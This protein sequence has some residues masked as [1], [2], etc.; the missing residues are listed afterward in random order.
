MHRC[1]RLSSL[2]VCAGGLLLW[3]SCLRSPLEADAPASLDPGSLASLDQTVEQVE[4]FP[5][6]RLPKRALP[7]EAGLRRPGR[8]PLPEK[9]PSLAPV[10][11]QSKAEPATHG[12]EQSAAA[13]LAAPN[14]ES[15]PHS[16]ALPPATLATRGP[17]SAAPPRERETQGD[18]LASKHAANG[19]RKDMERHTDSPSLPP[20]P[21]EQGQ[22][23]GKAPVG[24]PPPQIFA[25][26]DP[27]AREER[28]ASPRLS[29]EVETSEEAL[30]AEEK[31]TSRPRL[32]PEARF[33]VQIMSTS[34]PENAEDMRLQ[35][36]LVFPNEAVEVVWDPPNY[37]VRVGGAASMEAAQ[38]VK[39][40]AMRLGFTNAWVV[41]RRTH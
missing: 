35:A 17:A 32:G 12:Q 25:G 39:R 4:D 9:R 30:E 34:D 15:H 21:V 2:G 36:E 14:L 31:A 16:P 27:P 6:E 37:K 3:Q 5:V 1:S 10:L 26:E 19:V 41:P 38:E 11:A 13:A 20:E 8:G 33:Q 28:E 24:G 18:S 7:L 29:A 22:H 23:A 40:R